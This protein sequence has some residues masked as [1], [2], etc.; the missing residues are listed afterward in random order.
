LNNSVPESQPK[1]NVTMSELRPRQPNNFKEPKA[2]NSSQDSSVQ[3]IQDK[4]KLRPKPPLPKNLT[5][6]TQTEGNELNGLRYQRFNNEYLPSPTGNRKLSFGTQTDLTSN[7]TAPVTTENNNKV[8][9]EPTASNKSSP[10]SN[11]MENK[12]GGSSF[13]QYDYGSIPRY[14]DSNRQSMNNSQQLPTV[15]ANQNYNPVSMANDKSRYPFSDNFNK[16]RDVEASFG[17]ILIAD[18]KMS[19]MC[20]KRQHD[21]YEEFI[22][23][24]PKPSLDPKKRIK[25]LHIKFKQRGIRRKR[26]EYNITTMRHAKSRHA[27]SIKGNERHL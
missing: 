5:I 27:A 9:G 13:G 23:A 18:P 10:R 4:P 11:P 25:S 20:F 19:D 2:L 21:S 24:M 3:S 22:Q 7:G 17:N 14:V 8:F 26:L 16:K 1:Q 12:V 6:D 15:E